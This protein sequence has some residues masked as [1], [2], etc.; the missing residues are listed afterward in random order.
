MLAFQPSCLTLEQHKN[1]SKA[2]VTRKRPTN[3]LSG[4]KR[5]KRIGF[6]VPGW[7]FSYLNGS[8][9]VCQ[10]SFG[11]HMFGPIQY[12]HEK[13]PLAEPADFLLAQSAHYIRG[14][15]NKTLI[16]LFRPFK[17]YI[18]RK[19]GDSKH[20]GV[21][22][23]INILSSDWLFSPIA[24]AQQIMQTLLIYQLFL[25]L[26]L[27]ILCGLID[28]RPNRACVS[29]WNQNKHNWLRLQRLS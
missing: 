22:P 20:V 2:A 26:L 18:V 8:L 27:N 12:W 21:E 25:H 23:V 1:K 19:P 11:F 3:F 5:N 6:R 14:M 10:A 4:Y 17:C 28:A 16:R 24:G 7:R 9:D 13:P 15:K 29:R